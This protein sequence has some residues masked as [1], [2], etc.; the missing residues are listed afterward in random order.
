MKMYDKEKRTLLRHLL[1][2]PMQWYTINALTWEGFI[3]TISDLNSN[4][5]GLGLWGTWGWAHHF[6]KTAD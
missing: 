6:P 1:T 4:F 5:N 3:K 2:K